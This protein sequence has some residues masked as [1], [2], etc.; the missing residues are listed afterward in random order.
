M[1][2]MKVKSKGAGAPLKDIEVVSTAT[3]PTVVL[4]GE[5]KRIAEAAGVTKF[6]LSISHSEDVAVAVAVA[7]K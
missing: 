1:K 5:V 4:H 2:S 7:S 3:G 6:E